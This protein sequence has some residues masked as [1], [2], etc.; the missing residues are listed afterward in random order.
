M[1]S[2]TTRLKLILTKQ[3]SGFQKREMCPLGMMKKSRRQT[4]VQMCL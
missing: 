2:M 3:E 4:P 1:I